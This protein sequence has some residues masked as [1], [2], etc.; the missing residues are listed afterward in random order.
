MARPR[1]T[2]RGERS[3]PKATHGGH[4]LGA[5]APGGNVNAFKHGLSSAKYDQRLLEASHKNDR[6]VLA[7]MR[8]LLHIYRHGDLS[9]SERERLIHQAGLVALTTWHGL[10]HALL[11]EQSSW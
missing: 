5:G 7:H 3:P 6:A 2:R 11:A 9:R 10:S 8:D 1:A 4:R